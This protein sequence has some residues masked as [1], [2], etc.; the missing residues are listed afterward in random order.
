MYGKQKCHK[1]RDTSYLGR[2]FR[3][4]GRYSTFRRN[5]RTIFQKKRDNRT[6]VC[7]WKRIAWITIYTIQRVRK[8]K[9]GTNSQICMHEFKKISD[10]E[11]KERTINIKIFPVFCKY[12][13]EERRV[14]KE[15]RS[16]WSP[17]H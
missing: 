14:G 1:T 3:N 8:S 10:L 15:C 5:A 6:S 12:R 16:R 17:Y 4:S 7:G 9:N 2:V 11:S 13:S